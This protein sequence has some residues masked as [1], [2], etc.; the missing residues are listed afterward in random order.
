[1]EEMKH[2]GVGISAFVCGLVALVATLF[3]L[4]WAGVEHANSGGA[5][6]DE[7]S[8]VAVMIGLALFAEIFLGLI[9]VALGLGS[10]FQS[11]RKKVFGIIGLALAL[12][13]VLGT[14]GIIAFGMSQQQ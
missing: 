12:T 10:L 6:I 13:Q 14:V 7:K 4:G 9:A 8:P 5:G 3:T 1:M 11:N 2:S